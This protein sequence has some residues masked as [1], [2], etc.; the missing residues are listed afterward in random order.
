MIRTAMP[1]APHFLVAKVE[2]ETIRAHPSNPRKTYGRA[3]REE[4]R[5]A[6][7]EAGEPHRTNQRDRS[8]K[9][10]VGYD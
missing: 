3:M 6:A 5:E 7:R 10:F 2:T 1:P 8:M 9:G 4:F